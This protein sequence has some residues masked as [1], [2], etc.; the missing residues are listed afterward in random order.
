VKAVSCLSDVPYTTAY[1][2]I[3]PQVQC[4]I[5]GGVQLA[6]CKAISKYKFHCNKIKTVPMY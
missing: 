1:C 5:E 6:V 4:S 3:P 2:N